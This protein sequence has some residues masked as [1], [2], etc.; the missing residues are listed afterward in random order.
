M[1]YIKTFRYFQGNKQDDFVAMAMKMHL[2]GRRFVNYV[3]ICRDLKK[4]QIKK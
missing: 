3:E 1:N 2:E 4:N